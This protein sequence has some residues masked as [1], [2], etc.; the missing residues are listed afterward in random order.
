MEQ[1]LL[2]HANAIKEGAASLLAAVLFN[3]Q[4]FGQR[5]EKFRSSVK[6]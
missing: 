1:D 2:M 5:R 6:S 4:G 3:G